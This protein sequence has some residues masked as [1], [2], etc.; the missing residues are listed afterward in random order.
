MD[1]NIASQD[2]RQKQERRQ[3]Q[4]FHQEASG[5]KKCF[6]CGAN[7]SLTAEICTSCGRPVNPNICT[8]CGNPMEMDDLFCG[9]CGNPRKGI[10]CPECGTLNFRSFCRNCNHPLNPMAQDEMEK[11]A[12]DPTFQQI[13]EVQKQIVELEEQLNADY[14][15]PEQQTTNDQ[16]P[17]QFEQSEQSTQPNSTPDTLNQL[18]E[19]YDAK[20]QEMNKMLSSM[21]PAPG[22]SPQIQR[23]YYSARKLPFIGTTTSKNIIR[24]KIGWV[25]NYCGYTH[26]CPSECCEPQLGGTWLY[27]E[28]EVITPD[29]NKK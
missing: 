9:E 16:H 8:F 23:N 17:E 15:L 27:K 24:K 1:H 12:K 11:A 22:T 26:K 3:P 21:M 2:I 13:C 25:C 6:H 28:I 5:G 7:I 4:N 19:E 29:T 20:V 14:Q 18:S 10:V